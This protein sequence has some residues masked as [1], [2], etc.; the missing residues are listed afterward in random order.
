[1]ASAPL[2]PTVVDEHDSDR[3]EE[4]PR[5][6]GWY[7][8]ALFHAAAS[9]LGHTIFDDEHHALAS[10]VRALEGRFTPARP[11]PPFFITCGSRDPLLPQ[12]QRLKSALDRLHTPAEL[13]IAPGEIHAFDAMIWRAPARAKW[14]ATHA[15]LTRYLSKAEQTP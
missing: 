3:S 4:H 12:C 14:K 15:F 2:H 6:A 1:M 9:Y 10:P 11:L 7:K 5:L 8:S 13:F